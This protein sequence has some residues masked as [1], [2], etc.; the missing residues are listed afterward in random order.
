MNSTD[1]SSNCHTALLVRTAFSMALLGCFGSLAHAA[2]DDLTELSLEDLMKVVVVSASKFSQSSSQAPS[3]VQVISSEEIRQYG[4]RTLAEALNSLPGMYAS[5]DRAYGFLGARGFKIPGDY[6]MRFLLLLNGQPMNDN[7][8]GQPNLGHEFQLNMGL[9]DRIEYVPGPGSSIYGSNAM[10][11]VINV[12]TASAD[13]LAGVKLGARVQGDGWRELNLLSAHKAQGGGPNLVFGLSRANKSG[14]DL[15][16]PD[17]IGLVT[18][19]GSPSIDGMTH[20]LDQMMV[21]RSFLEVRQDAWAIFAWAARRD[22]Q[23]SSPLF[24]SNFND[25]RLRLVDS[26]YG[27][28]SSYQALLSDQHTMNFR[29]AYQRMTYSSD[30]PT[31]DEAGIASVSRDQALGNWLSG[32]ARWLYSGWDK[33]KI[34]AGIDFQYD[35]EA[36][37]KNFNLDDV[38]SP[39]FAVH[40]PQRRYGVFVQDEWNFLPDWR[41]NV[42]LRHDDYS[43]RKTSVSPRLGLIWSATERA[44]FKLLA[45]RAYRAP[46]AYEVSYARSPTFIANPNLSSEIIRTV[47]AV[48]EYRLAAG[49]EIGASLFDYRLTDLVRQVDL[50]GGQLQYQNQAAVYARGAEIFYKL[51]SNHGLNLTGS[52]AFNRSHDSWEASLSNSPSWIAKLRLAQPVWQDKLTLAAELN[53]LAPRSVVWHDE[54]RELATQTQMNLVLNSNRLLPGVDLQLRLVNVFNARLTSPASTDTSVATLPADGRQ[55]QLGC[56]YGF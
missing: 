18:A 46:N 36:V 47:E 20:N 45:G 9:I 24:G 56:R 54:K 3:A 17:A 42:G 34:I 48:A 28:S 2:A 23:P 22:V 39:P 33:H 51:R 21:T 29:L 14:H 50:G 52:I 53:V 31:T 1:T 32:E 6:N 44:T 26:S 12:I 49:Q 37:Q 55:W 27:L 40:T 7:V 35:L 25:A 43:N 4:W 10:F 8:Y 11:G 41:L 13:K 5:S 15:R 19:D 16:Y 38:A 30:V